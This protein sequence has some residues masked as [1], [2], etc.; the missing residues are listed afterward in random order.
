MENNQEQN[1][2]YSSKTKP[3]ISEQLLKQGFLFIEEIETINEERINHLIKKEHINANLISDGYHT[4]G[5][6]YE[7]RIVLFIATCTLIDNLH[8][9]YHKVIAKNEVIRQT[10]SPVWKSKIHSDGSIW[11]GWFI[12]GIFSEA[13]KQITYHLPDD[14][15]RDCN[16]RVLEKAPEYDGHTAQDVLDRLKKI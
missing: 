13:G 3:E 1:K 12:L 14:K 11:E 10:N 8:I 16:F 9:H 6:L 2:D 7:H 5:E 15:W 4:F